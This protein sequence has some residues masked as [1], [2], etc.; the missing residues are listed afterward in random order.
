MRMYDGY[1]CFFYFWNNFDKSFKCCINTVVT[2][3]LFMCVS[4]WAIGLFFKPSLS[5][6]CEFSL[7][8]SYFCFSMTGNFFFFLLVL[9]YIPLIVFSFVIV[10][11]FERLLIV[12][13]IWKLLWW[14]E[15]ILW[16][17]G[18]KKQ[19]GMIIVVNTLIIQKLRRTTTRRSH[20]KVTNLK[21]EL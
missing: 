16:C 8:H 13:P 11:K 18:F 5:M 3:Y 19:L 15:L 2:K 14:T 20:K 4:E 1:V 9:C 6:W 17:G 7:S 21:V 12:A 10:S